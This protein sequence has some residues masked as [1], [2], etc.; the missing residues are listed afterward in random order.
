MRCA[1]SI[2]TRSPIVVAQAVVDLAEAVQVDQ[3]Q[4]EAAAVA[5]ARAALACGHALGQLAAVGQAG[6]RVGAATAPRCAAAPP[7][8]RSGRGTNTPGPSAWPRHH[9]GRVT[10]SST[11]PECSVSRSVALQQRRVLRW[12]A[13]GAGR[14]SASATLRRIQSCTAASSRDLQQVL[15]HAPDL[16]EAAVEGADAARQVGHQDAVGGGFQRG[17]QLGHAAARARPRR[18]ARRCGRR[19]PPA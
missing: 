11:W 9:S 10:R 17:L 1:T 4:R 8:A 15:G 12:P 7:A 3:Q 6:Q 13:G 5:G 18:G 16:R 2:S 14:P 19:P